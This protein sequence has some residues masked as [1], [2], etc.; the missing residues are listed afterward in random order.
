MG[1]VFLG[2]RA[3]GDPKNAHCRSDEARLDGQPPALAQLTQIVVAMLP[4]CFV[5]VYNIGITWQQHCENVLLFLNPGS[6]KGL[7]EIVLGASGL[8][9]LA[10]R[11]VGLIW[12]VT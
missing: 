6:C 2:R 7:W 9:P 12:A 10:A 1:C 8:L 11:S 3:E 4:V 5:N